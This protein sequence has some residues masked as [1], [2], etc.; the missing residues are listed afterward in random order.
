[1]EGGAGWAAATRVSPLGTG[2]RLC[3]VADIGIYREGLAEAL[4]RRQGL[5]VV[6]TA[7]TAAEAVVRARELSPDV[8]LLHLAGEDGVG[9][10][11][12]LVAAAAT[13]RVV[14][15]AVPEAERHVIAYAEAGAA[16]YVTLEDSLDELVVVIESVVRGEMPCS[17][18]V[19]ASLLRRLSVLGARP[20]GPTSP[21]AHLTAREIQILALLQRGLSNK[22]IARQL[23]I[24]LSTV[25]NHVH[26]ILQKLQVSDRAEAAAWGRSQVPAAP[27][28]DVVG[29]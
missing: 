26:R 10:V 25:K 2:I 1:M 15:L 23:V 3:V 14:A 13:A 19:A 22:Q 9:A 16:G 12:A 29:V 21:D 7:A 8:V 18:R 5:A 24:E 28:A 20:A 27:R 6:G 11:R 17:P 4:G